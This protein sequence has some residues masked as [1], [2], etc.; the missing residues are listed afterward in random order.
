M[1]LADVEATLPNG[2]HDAEIMELVWNYQTNSASDKLSFSGR[3]MDK[4]IRDR[5]I[6]K[7]TPLN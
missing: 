7:K 6:L 2:F 1:T 4:G 5:V 3:N